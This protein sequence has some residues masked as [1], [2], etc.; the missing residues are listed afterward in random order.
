[1]ETKLENSCFAISLMP[2][3]GEK[4]TRHQPLNHAYHPIPNQ[5]KSSIH[6]EEHFENM[7]SHHTLHALKRGAFHR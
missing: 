1:M 2:P 5:D 4:V 7:G 3:I 6:N